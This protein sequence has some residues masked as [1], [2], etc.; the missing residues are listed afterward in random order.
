MLI[1]RACKDG[2]A[3]IYAEVSTAPDEYGRVD[4][5]NCRLKFTGDPSN[6][7][8]AQFVC[9][10]ALALVFNLKE[11]PINSED[12]FGTPVEML[13]DVLLNRLT[14]TTVRP[15]LVV[16]DARKDVVGCEWGMYA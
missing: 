10:A 14:D 2:F 15:A 9:E 6:F 8:T 1:R 11:L 4:K 5:G 12:G 7:E 13:G 3:E 16:T